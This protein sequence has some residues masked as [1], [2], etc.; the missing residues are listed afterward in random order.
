MASEFFA[1]HDDSGDILQTIVEL[2]TCLQNNTADVVLFGVPA[3]IGFSKSSNME[4]PGYFLTAPIMAKGLRAATLEQRKEA[5]SMSFLIGEGLVSP[6][7]FLCF[8][9]TLFGF[10]LALYVISA[11]YK[12]WL[13]AG[14]REYVFSQCFW[15]FYSIAMSI[16]AELEPI[17]WSGRILTGVWSFW[18]I[19][20]WALLTA[21]MAAVFG[22]NLAHR[23]LTDINQLGARGSQIKAFIF[24]YLRPT[25]EIFTAEPFSQL[26]NENRLKFVA[27][28]D[29][30][31]LRDELLKGD[32]VLIGAELHFDHLRRSDEHL[33]ELYFLDGSLTFEP[34]SFAL[35]SNWSRA[36]KVNE[37]LLKMGSSGVINEIMRNHQS[38]S[39]ARPSNPSTEIGAFK[40]VP[41]FILLAVTVVV[42]II[43]ALGTIFCG[44]RHKRDIVAE[45][46][47]EVDSKDVRGDPG[48]REL[49]WPSILN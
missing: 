41:F 26:R 35:R 29:A 42:S 1:L 34:Y 27:E 32:A 10:S 12:K 8:W 11:M 38:D 47:D 44:R 48:K 28:N 14:E 2:L 46:N 31:F 36:V 18:T 49:P 4:P 15:Y 5:F 43:V 21:N 23:P 9:L 6:F 39:F 24:E 7:A 19:Y 13:P 30:K 33:R 20:C 16:G 22:N 37:L 45:I 17:S 3:S 25:S 40:L